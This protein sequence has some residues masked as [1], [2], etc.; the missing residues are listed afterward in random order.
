[1]QARAFQALDQWFLT[2]QG[3]AV[4]SSFIEELKSWKELKQSMRGDCL[5]QLGT[6]GDHNW[7]PLF[8]YKTKLIISPCTYNYKNVQSAHVL[9]LIKALPFAESSIDCLISPMALEPHS[10][11]LHPLDEFD[12]VL[13]PMG[14]IV[15]LGISALSL[16]GL[17]LRFGNL[18]Y[19]ARG[20]INPVS[21][22]K[23]K[24]ALL[25][26]GYSLCYLE[27]FFYI[28][29]AKSKKWLDR[30]E[31]FNEL[32]KMISPC[33]GGFYCMIV[34]KYIPQHTNPL[35]EQVFWTNDKH[36]AAMH[37]VGC[38]SRRSSINGINR[39]N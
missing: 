23:L 29:P 2:A 3:Q 17:A 19:L 9:G 6:A 1:M 39:S 18:P 16:W 15:F 12:R 24:H 22:F 7:L 35:L 4:S 8:N 5:L 36:P 34:Q 25:H 20:L 28:P 31:I 26:R 14:Y 27:P 33:P 32:G 37:P 30:L 38:G 13:K 10:W 11:P 21:I